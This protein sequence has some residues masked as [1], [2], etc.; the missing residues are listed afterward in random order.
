MVRIAAPIWMAALG[1]VFAEQS[2]VLNIGLEGMMLMGAFSGFMGAFFTGSNWAGVLIG[3]LAGGALSLILAYMSL[4]RGVDQVVTGIAINV[5]ALGATSY[6]FNRAF[7]ITFEP[8]RIHAFR[9]WA[10]PAL[11]DLPW[12][13]PVLFRQTPLVYLAFA[14]VPVCALVLYRTKFGLKIRAVGE[15]PLAADTAGVHVNRVRGVCILLSGWMA[16]FGGAILSVGQVDVFLENMTAGRGFI[17]LAVVVFGKWNPF[18]V[19]GAALLFG[20][21]DA[22]QLRLQAL[23]FKIPF[24]FLLMAPY[25]LTVVVLVG[26]VGKASYPAATGI[27]YLTE[28]RRRRRAP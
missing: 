16:G 1:E 7:A 17:A 4:S 27:P 22:L 19:L 5:F 15:H 20:L 18:W 11:G 28:K 21:A 3:S 13:G 14:L 25:V 26:V 8:P 23:G 24:Q 6:L 9:A 12:V 2:G 10:I